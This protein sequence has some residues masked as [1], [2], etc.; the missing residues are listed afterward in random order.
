MYAT[1][2]GGAGL[3]FYSFDLVNVNVPS[4]INWGPWFES[5]I[6]AGSELGFGQISSAATS[7]PVTAGQNTPAPAS[8]VYQIGQVPGSLL[9]PHNGASGQENYG[10][11]VLLASGSYADSAQAGFGAEVLADVF[12]AEGA[13]TTT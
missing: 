13:V 6:G 9:G 7:S 8:L 1:V 3:A 5:S 4:I 11:P 10:A 2:I 12:D